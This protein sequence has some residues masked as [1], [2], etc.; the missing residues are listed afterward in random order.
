MLI[1]MTSN[2]GNSMKKDRE[3]LSQE[4]VPKSINS[5]L[6]P[7]EM[8]TV[9][10]HDVSDNCDHLIYSALIPTS[11]IGECL[12]NP[13][14]DLTLGRGL[15]GAIES[16]GGFSESSVE[17]YRYGDRYFEP[18]VIKRRFNGIRPEYFEINEEFRLFHDLYHDPKKIS[19]SRLMLMA[20]K[21]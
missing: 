18:L 9:F 21:T 19:L 12:E 1:Q 10:S 7:D 14:W 2:S 13:S 16:S 6:R 4:T 17:Y 15:P 20:Q 3:R 5:E 11:H 8:L